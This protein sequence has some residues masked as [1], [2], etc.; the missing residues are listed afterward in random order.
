MLDRLQQHDGERAP[1]LAAYLLG[2]LGFDDLGALQRRL[3]YDVSGDRD[4]AAVV[5]CE[6][7][8]GI[9]VGREGSAAHI[10]PNAAALAARRWPVRWV[11]RGGGAVLHQPGQVACFPVLPLDALNLTPGRY[12]SELEAVCLDLCRDYGLE[13]QRDPERPGVRAGGRRIAHV[14]V[15]VRDGV[16]SFGIVLNA[17]PDLVPF[18]DV[19]CDGDPLP[20]TSL[21]RESPLRVRVPAVRQKLLELVAT[22]FGFARVSVFHHHPAALPRATRHALPHAS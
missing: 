5:L 10:R 14:G 6:L 20:M 21:Q 16:S 3:R 7:E 8:P 15:A 13:A 9:T 4:T 11:A 12:V 19:R 18:R 22:R 2:S 17:N 1:A